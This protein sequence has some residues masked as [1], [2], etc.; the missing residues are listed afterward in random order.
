MFR[1]SDR[2]F[3]PI[4]VIHSNPNAFVGDVLCLKRPP[5]TTPQQ[6][7]SQTIAKQPS[8]FKS[9]I[10]IL[11]VIIVAMSSWWAYNASLLVDWNRVLE[12]VLQKSEYLFLA[13]VNLPFWLFD[14]LIEFPLRELYRHGPSLVG[15]EGE[16]LPRICARVTY[17]GDEEFWSRN[18]EECER[19]FLSKEAAAMQVRK[20][21]LISFLCIIAFYMV[22]SIVEARALRQRERIDPNMV[23]TFRAINM[24]TRQLRRAMDAR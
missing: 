17:H 11:A 4:S 14:V 6:R 21:L 3:I 24:L 2:V 9:F 8:I 16:P 5:A 13:T 7:R 23:E 22:K 20:P 18:L 15:W 1:E 12:M 19:I 10:E